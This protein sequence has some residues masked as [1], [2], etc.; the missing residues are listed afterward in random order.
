MNRIQAYL[1]LDGRHDYRIASI[2]QS[3]EPGP[4]TE[5]AEKVSSDTSDLEL[6]PVR[7]NSD[8]PNVVEI[9]DGCFGWDPAKEPNLRNV[10]IQ[11]PR[12]KLTIITGAVGS[13][14][15]TLVKAM[16]GETPIARGTTRTFFTKAAYCDQTPWITNSTVKSNIIGFSEVD[17]VFYH[18]VIHACALEEDLT[19]F[20]NGDQE[21]LGS[22]GTSLS[23]GQK[24]RL[25]GCCQISGLLISLTCTG[26]G[27]SYILPKFLFSFR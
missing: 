17:E 15:S 1:R 25:V 6:H 26:A 10:N 24:R 21:T 19:A 22:K 3:S 12:G 14:K 5:H 13:G 2:N 9:S 27:E 8:P 16:M 4:N 11:I 7:I 18:R 23:G 20:P